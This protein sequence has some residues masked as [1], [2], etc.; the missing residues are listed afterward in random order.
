M[1]TADGLAVGPPLGVTGE[2]E[3]PATFLLTVKFVHRAGRQHPCGVFGPELFQPAHGSQVTVLADGL[4][5]EEVSNLA[6]VLAHPY[7]LGPSGANV[8]KHQHK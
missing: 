5:V 4:R 7:P 2:S 1:P 3:R 6:A 8:K